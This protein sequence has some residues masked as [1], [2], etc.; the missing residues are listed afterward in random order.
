MDW[1]L[2]VTPDGDKMIRDTKILGT[3]HSYETERFKE[4]DIERFPDKLYYSV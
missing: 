1:T 4:G 3:Q 2:R